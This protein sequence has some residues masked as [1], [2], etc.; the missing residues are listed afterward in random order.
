MGTFW[1]GSVGNENVYFQCCCLLLV[2]IIW[3]TV[4]QCHFEQFLNCDTN[5][6]KRSSIQSSS[7]WCQA[8]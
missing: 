7:F 2:I 4:T 3:C 5:Q 6:K 1:V 8:N